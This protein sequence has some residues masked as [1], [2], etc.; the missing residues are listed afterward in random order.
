MIFNDEPLIGMLP[1]KSIW[2]HCDLNLSPFD[3]KIK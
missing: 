1:L 2:S 3:L